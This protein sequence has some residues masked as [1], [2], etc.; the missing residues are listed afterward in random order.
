MQI[1]CTIFMLAFEPLFSMNK[2][3]AKGYIIFHSCKTVNIM[4]ILTCTL[5]IQGMKNKQ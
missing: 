5:N 3:V 1:F 2:S 4:Y